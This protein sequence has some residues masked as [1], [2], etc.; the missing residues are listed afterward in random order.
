MIT[1]LREIRVQCKRVGYAKALMTTNC[2]RRRERPPFIRTRL[3]QRPRFR[4]YIA[5]DEDDID[6][7]RNSARH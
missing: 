6:M 4:M 2:S 7:R 3:E 5:L 1:G